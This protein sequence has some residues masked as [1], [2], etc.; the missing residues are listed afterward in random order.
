MEDTAV[1]R[2]LRR[3]I[4]HKVLDVTAVQFP[5]AAVVADRIATDDVVEEIV[6][7]LIHLGIN[8]RIWPTLYE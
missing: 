2:T 1:E 4:N 3:F 7:I 6:E 5:S 8:V